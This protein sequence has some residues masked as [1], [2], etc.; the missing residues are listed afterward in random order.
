[1]IKT[2]VVDTNVLIQAPFNALKTTMWSFPW[3]FWRS[4]TI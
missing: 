4:W 3:L 1:M 2:Y